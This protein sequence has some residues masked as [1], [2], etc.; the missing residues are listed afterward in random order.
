MQFFGLRRDD[1][2]ALLLHLLRDVVEEGKQTVVFV[3]TKHHVEYLSELL[4]AQ[5][6]S[7]TYSYGESASRPK[8]TARRRFEQRWESK[9]GSTIHMNRSQ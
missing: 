5:E 4:T 3:A 1:K 6:I 2:P 8:G 9:S 7:C